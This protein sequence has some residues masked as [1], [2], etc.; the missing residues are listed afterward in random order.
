MK[1]LAKS[2]SYKFVLVY[3]L[4][5]HDSTFEHGKYNNNNNTTHSTR[6]AEI[7]LLLV[8]WWNNLEIFFVGFHKRWAIKTKIKINAFLVWEKDNKNPSASLY[9]FEWRKL[10]MNKYKNNSLIKN[11]KILNTFNCSYKFL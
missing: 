5:W 4:I 9:V 10:R 11:P 7:F 1:N 6:H 8:D 3:A 2:V